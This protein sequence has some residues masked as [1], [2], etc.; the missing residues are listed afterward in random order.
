MSK[1]LTLIKSCCK[2]GKRGGGVKCVKFY[3]KEKK[4]NAVFCR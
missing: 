2:K 4:K 3:E 1:T